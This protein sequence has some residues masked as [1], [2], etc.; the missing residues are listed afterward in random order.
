MDS[1]CFA[2][3]TEVSWLK[4]K[5]KKSTTSFSKRREKNVGNGIHRQEPRAGEMSG[6]CCVP[7]LRGARPC[8]VWD[9]VSQACTL[10]LK[11]ETSLL[12]LCQP[13]AEQDY[14]GKVWVL[15]ILGVGFCQITPEENP[16]SKAVVVLDCVPSLP[17]YVPQIPQ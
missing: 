3:V 16:R 13:C 17:C 4:F 5:I 12:S 15:S 14:E 10:P 6:L 7:A 8:G 11:M 9:L 2:N 1:L